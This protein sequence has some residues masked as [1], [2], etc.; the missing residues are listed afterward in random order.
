MNILRGTPTVWGMGSGFLISVFDF[1]ENSRFLRTFQNKTKKRV[2]NKNNH[3]TSNRCRPPPKSVSGLMLFIL[4]FSV[5]VFFLGGGVG[6]AWFV[7]GFLKPHFSPSHAE[8]SSWGYGSK[9]N[10]Q[11]LDRWFSSMYPSRV[12]VSRFFDPQPWR[13]L[14]FTSAKK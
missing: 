2:V 5:F 8:A 4:H 1:W 7:F 6:V 11:D 12:E 14:R 3:Q 10:H 13:S 9:L